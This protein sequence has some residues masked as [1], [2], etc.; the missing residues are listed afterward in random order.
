MFIGFLLF[1]FFNL[2]FPQVLALKV[3]NLE[4]KHAFLIILY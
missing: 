4:S 3:D 2:G 1:Y